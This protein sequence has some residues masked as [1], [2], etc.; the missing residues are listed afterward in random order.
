MK[1]YKIKNHNYDT[2]TARYGFVDGDVLA[3]G[4]ELRLFPEHSLNKVLF[5]YYDWLEL[6]PDDFDTLD[7]A[8][9]KLYL[10]L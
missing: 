7:E 4:V 1:W 8:S 2:V 3:H 6:L 5:F 9:K 10:E